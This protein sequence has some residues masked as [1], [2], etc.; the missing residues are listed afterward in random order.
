MYMCGVCACVYKC[1]CTVCAMHARR[2][3]RRTIS[4]LFY[5]YLFLWY[6]LLLNLD[7]AIITPVCLHTQRERE[8]N[9][10]GSQACTT[11]PSFLHRLR[12]SCLQSR[13]TCLWTISPTPFHSSLQLK[14]L[15][16]VSVDGYVAR[17]VIYWNSAVLG[18]YPQNWW[19]EF[20]FISFVVAPIY[21]SAN[22]IW[23]SLLT[24]TCFLHSSHSGCGEM[25]SQCHF[26]VP[27][28][29]P[30]ATVEGDEHFLKFTCCL[31]SVSQGL[32]VYFICSFSDW[33]ICLG[34][35]W[36]F[37]YSLNSLDINP[38]SCLSGKD[39]SPIL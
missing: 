39:F 26:S 19:S 11:I 24:S 25:E 4:V 20:G 10:W 14:K 28:S 9:N 18:V 15:Y 6:S 33:L 32:S 1:T 22:S 12:S 29:P 21:I 17:S 38:I 27:S 13:C 7:F 35:T 23:G 36:F 34:G 31:Y 3:P 16:C 8:R 30:P 5:H 37:T 2:W